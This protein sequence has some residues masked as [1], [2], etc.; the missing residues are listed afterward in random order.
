MPK[1]QAGSSRND[2]VVIRAPKDLIEDVTKY[3]TERYGKPVQFTEAA[4]LYAADHKNMRQ[5]LNT[6]KGS[7][8]L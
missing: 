7:N 8:F 3:A 2:T 1:G 6:R 5:S 4:R